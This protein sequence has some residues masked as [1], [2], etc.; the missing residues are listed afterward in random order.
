MNSQAHYNKSFLLLTFLVVMALTS[1]SFKRGGCDKETLL[2]MA[3]EKLKK[4]TL[5]QDFPFFM[6]KKKKKEE[7]GPEIKKQVITLN[8]GV[9]YKFFA[10]RNPDYPGMPVVTI[11]NNEKMEFLVGT[12][13]NAQLQKFYEVIEFECK[14]T[15]NYLLVFSIQNNLEGCGLGVFSSLVKD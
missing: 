12:T 15:G 8:R 2:P 6:N 4:F 1:L 5:I 10:I 7:V 3:M 11:Y 13:F 14:T 9:R